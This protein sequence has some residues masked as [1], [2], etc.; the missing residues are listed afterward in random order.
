MGRV[1]AFGRGA[2]RGAGGGVGGGG[3]LVER[4][5]AATQAGAERPVRR[6][7]ALAPRGGSAEAAVGEAGGGGKAAP[8]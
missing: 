6:V 3:R 1:A 4:V 5:S 8:G 7:A 2:A